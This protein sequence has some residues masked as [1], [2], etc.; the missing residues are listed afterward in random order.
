MQSI[1]QLDGHL[2]QTYRLVTADG[3]LYTL[4]VHP[5][6]N[7]RLLRQES[8]NI[9][10]EAQLLRLIGSKAEVFTPK[11][12]E[13]HT[14]TI[15]I[16]SYYLLTGPIK[17]TVLSGLIS[18][19]SS[20]QRM[21]IDKSLGSYVRSLSNLRA[22]NFG[23]VRQIQAGS[24]LDSWSKAFI[25]LIETV[26]RDAEDA[27]VSLPYDSIRGHVIRHRSALDR[28]SEPQLVVLD[29]ASPTNIL[30][31][32]NTSQMTGLL[33]YSH[34]VWGDPRMAECFVEPSEA[35]LRGFGR[36]STLV[37][38]GQRARQLL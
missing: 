19:T 36:S 13:H 24:G 7:A 8:D 2:Y 37:Y 17:G 25:Y 32:E 21:S 22:I 31:D 35:F 5:H 20:A 34:A 23:S 29:A 3:K 16:G 15:P 11:V 27:L 1:R 9:D 38:E 26:L 4:K 30:V 14:T 28:I 33:D 12:V 18:R 10:G 6:Y